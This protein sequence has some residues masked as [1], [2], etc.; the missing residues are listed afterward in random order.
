MNIAIFGCG[1]VGGTTADWL[2]SQGHS[3]F[4]IDPKHHPM[5]DKDEALMECSHVIIAVP[6]SSYTRIKDDYLKV[7]LI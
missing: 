3:V 4:R 1:Y 7:G 5:T 6:I 2:E